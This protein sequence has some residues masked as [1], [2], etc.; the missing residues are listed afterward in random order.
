MVVSPETMIAGV[1][2]D[3]VGHS[4]AKLRIGRHLHHR[5]NR[6]PCRRTQPRRKQNDIRPRAHLRG[7]TLHI[8]TRRALQIQSRLP[9]DTPDNP[10]PPSPVTMPPFF[11]APGGFHRVGQQSIADIS[12]RRIHIKAG[13][14]GFRPRRIALISCMNR[15]ATSVGHASIDQLLFHSAKLRKFTQNRLPAQ[16]RQKIGDVPNGRI[17]R[18]SRKSV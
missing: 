14:D 5:C 17:R 6:I 1:D 10:A 12:R 3:D 11:A 4:P 16:R 2:V 9:R 18:N 7:D 13:I 15:S 8:V